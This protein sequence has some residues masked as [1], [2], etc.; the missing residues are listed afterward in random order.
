M[1]VPVTG[2]AGY[3]CR[4]LLEAGLAASCLAHGIERFTFASSASIYDSDA[5][6]RELER[7]PVMCDETTIVAPRGASISSSTRS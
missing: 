2:G 1:C 7:S 3:I 5:S 6:S 4:Q